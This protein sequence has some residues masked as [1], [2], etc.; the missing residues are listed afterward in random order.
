MLTWTKYRR[1]TP[2]EGWTREKTNAARERREKLYTSILALEQR[3]AAALVGSFGLAKVLLWRH[4]YAEAHRELVRALALLQEL[5][6]KLEND[7]DS[8]EDFRRDFS[9]DPPLVITG[10]GEYATYVC[11]G[12]V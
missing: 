12:D 2:P 6:E 7:L 9:D 5:G 10:Q 8:I 3:G 4:K 11:G 1:V